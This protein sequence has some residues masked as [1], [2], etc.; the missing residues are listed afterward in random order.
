MKHNKL[1]L[2]IIT[3][4]I[5]NLLLVSCQSGKT[6]AGKA[7]AIDQ[8]N[9]YLLDGNSNTYG[10]YKLSDFYLS[11]GDNFLLSYGTEGTILI[12]NG[13]FNGK[14]FESSNSE[15][16]KLCP[17]YNGDSGSSYISKTFKTVQSS[18]YIAAVSGEY[19]ID[20][21]HS[22]DFPYK[23]LITGYIYG[24]NCGSSR[25]NIKI[26]DYK[27]RY[28]PSWAYENI[29]PSLD[30]SSSS[31]IAAVW[32][33]EETKIMMTLYTSPSTGTICNAVS[34][35][36]D[37]QVNT[38]TGRN[39]NPS[40]KFIS[41]TSLV[42]I[43]ENN[44]DIYARIYSDKGVPLTS[45]FIVNSQTTGLKAFPS[46]SVFEDGKFIIAWQ[47][48]QIEDYDIHA[49]IYNPDG[50]I[51]QEEF[52]LQSG[53][54]DQEHPKLIIVS[55][56]LDFL[57][58]DEGGYFLFWDT[59]DAGSYSINGQLFNSQGRAL[60]PA[61]LVNDI[62]SGNKNTFFV[63]QSSMAQSQKIMV[64]WA[65]NKLLVSDNK[66]SILI[67]ADLYDILDLDGDLVSNFEDSCPYEAQ[68]Y[69]DG[70]NPDPDGDFICLNDI[71]PQDPLNDEDQDT[72]CGDVDNC[73]LVSNPTQDNADLSDE[74]INNQLILGDACDTDDDNDGVLD[75]EDCMGGSARCYDSNNLEAPQLCINSICASN[76]DADGDGIFDILD[77][78]PPIFCETNGLDPTICFNPND[79][80]DTDGDGLGDICD[81]DDDNDG[82][83]EDDGDGTI[84]LCDN[85]ITTDCDD[86]C[87][88]IKN[89][90]SVVATCDPNG[91]G[92][93]NP[94]EEVLCNQADVVGNDIGD[95]CDTICVQAEDYVLPI[96]NPQTGFSPSCDPRE[97][98]KTECIL[99]SLYT[100]LNT[101]NN[102]CEGLNNAGSN[103]YSSLIDCVSSCFSADCVAE[104]CDYDYDGLN[105]AVDNCDLITNGDQNNYDI[106][107]E[108][109]N[110]LPVQGDLCDPDD[111]NDGVLDTE[112]CF[113][114]SNPI[115]CIELEFCDPESSLCA[116]NIDDDG[117]GV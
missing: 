29:N 87:Q 110:S 104:S 58:L 54:G 91:D 101:L 50:T 59:L 33:P 66:N 28:L 43:W 46:V 75:T 96:C 103:S 114:G 41:L 24:P 36:T 84:D 77:T 80:Y 23:Q 81:T 39:I 21:D 37:I 31:K 57:P 19:S 72:V 78:C 63:A 97:E 48:N 6:L 105:N 26:Y 92:T 86:N 52:V 94:F 15:F 93:L 64:A 113:G 67:Y 98:C 20:S 35:E 88:L 4:L 106:V 13:Y 60:E 89:G 5:I 90:A 51:Y 14:L 116:S 55:P 83:L 65:E 40:V 32:S 17:I 11:G 18:D 70:S 102:P 45:V 115:N 112:D 69:A 8:K 42:V 79:Q 107:D 47:T 49:K 62:A 111:D 2:I 73:P 82:I 61:F 95:A 16:L 53:M 3:I 12:K 76:T 27:S 44:G 22:A 34:S 85:G 25:C 38:N 56:Q 7:V 30:I 68:M 1:I 99:N 117:D 10:E 109:S 74:Q 9:D 100:S 108:E 71:C